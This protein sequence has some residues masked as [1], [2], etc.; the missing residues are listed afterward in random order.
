MKTASNQWYVVPEVWLMLV[1]LTATVAGSL[2]LVSTAYRHNDE[3]RH[4]G[5]SIAS[6]L[7]PS[8]AARPADSATP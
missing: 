5:T 3:L 7:P 1:M 4:V 6:P 8:T 2:A